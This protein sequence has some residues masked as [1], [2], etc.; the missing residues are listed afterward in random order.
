M[1]RAII[2]AAILG[3]GGCANVGPLA[4]PSG[5][6]EITVPRK[7][8][9]HVKTELVA[10]MCAHGF[11]PVEDGQNSVAFSK[12]LEPGAA[13]AYTLA[14]GNAYSSQPQMNVRYSLIQQGNGVHVYA[15][16]GV[17]MQGGFGQSQSLDLTHGKAG[18]EVQEVLETL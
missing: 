6:P 12:P 15:F 18:R 4:T 7:D 13:F 10:T 16:V 17:A 11:E 9:E 8:L 3:L 14:M 5:N 1:T 2:M